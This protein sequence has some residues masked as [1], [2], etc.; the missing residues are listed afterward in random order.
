MRRWRSSSSGLRQRGSTSSLT[1]AN[2]A[3][4]AEIC[5]RLDGL[6]LAIELAAA[7]IKVLPVQAL[8]ARLSQ[9]LA[10]LKGGP[11]DVPV[12]Q[13]TLR[14]TITWSF[15]F[16]ETAEQQLFRRL[17]VFAGGCTLEAAEALSIALYG[18]AMMERYWIA[19]PHCWTI[20]YSPVERQRK[21]ATLCHA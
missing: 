15:G 10:V 8:L 17:S 9:R 21:G 14:N 2:A 18:G 7:R 5:V 1:T 4:V 20:A 16:L 12:R 19:W 13:Q 6:P 3:A 11:R